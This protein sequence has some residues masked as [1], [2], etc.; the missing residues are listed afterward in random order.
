MKKLIISALVFCVFA[1]NAQEKADTSS[2][3]FC[4][5]SN[6]TPLTFTSK[7]GMEVLPQA[8]DWGLGISA[9]APLNYFGSLIG[10]GATANN[11]FAAV[12]QSNTFITA[13]TTIFGKYM[14]NSNTAYRVRFSS[15]TSNVFTRSGLIADD[16]D[17]NKQVQ[18]TR[19]TIG[20]GI[21]IGAGVE[22]RRGYGRLIGIYGVEG[23][24]GIN[25]GTVTKFFYANQISA[26]NQTPTD[27]FGSNNNQITVDGIT[28]NRTIQ[29]GGNSGIGIG[30]VG[31]IG[32]EYFVAPRISIG[33]EFNLGIFYRPNTSSYTT[34][35][36]YNGNSGAVEE[37]TLATKGGRQLLSGTNTLGGNINLM[38]YF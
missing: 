30:A 18:D 5:K 19:T 12:N 8:G 16:G 37:Y 2:K 15:N 4:L 36:F 25:Q 7:N 33:G 23:L 13:G 17:V 34:V 22:K 21:V 20:R 28:D 10:D 35:E 11:V 31:F 26:S 14:V 27:G 1:A 32:L 3:R 24:L 38:F 29:T 6:N 9:T